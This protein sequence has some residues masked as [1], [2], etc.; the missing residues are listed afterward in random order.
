MVCYVSMPV[1]L[2]LSN[3]VSVTELELM[4]LHDELMAYKCYLYGPILFDVFGIL[5]YLEVKHQ[6]LQEESLD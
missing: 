5:V 4:V 6:Q 2:D 3:R 1:D